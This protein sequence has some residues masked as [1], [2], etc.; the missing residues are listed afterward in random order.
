MASQ[1]TIKQGDTLSGIARANNTTVGNIQTSNPNITDVNKIQAGSI[2]NIPSTSNISTSNYPIN[3]VI[4]ASDIQ[5]QKSVAIPTPINDTNASTNLGITNSIQ[6]SQ[7]I[8]DIKNSNTN[9]TQPVATPDKKT[10]SDKILSLIGMSGTKE[11]FTSDLQTEQDITGKTQELNKLNNDIALT[12]QSYDNQI[13]ELRKNDVGAVGGG[14]SAS[15]ND[16]TRKKN[17]DLANLAIRKSVALN[18]LNTANSIIDRKVSAKFEPIDNQIKSYEQL[19]TLLQN[20][21][22][23]KEKLQAQSNLETQKTNRDNV[24]SAL[25]DVYAN[26]AIN[27]AP[28]T[29]YNN[30]DKI[31][32]D[33]SNNKID[34][35]TAINLINKSAGKYT[36]KNKTSLGAGF[37]GNLSSSAQAVV[38][39]PNLINNFT[40][41][42]KGQII[43]E[44]SQA[45]YDISSLGSKP[46]SD[47]A[48]K[49]INQSNT[50]LSS[51]NDL[52]TIVSNNQDKIGPITGLS[53]LNPY[54]E[55]RKIQADIDRVKQQVGKSLEGGVLRKEDEVKYKK[56]LATITDT[57]D[58]ALYKI[59]ELIKNIDKSINDY[60]NLQ[61]GS[62]R[63]SNVTD[64][65]Q[66]KDNSTKNDNKT[67]VNTPNI[68]ELRTKYGY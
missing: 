38:D 27:K 61:L 63:S 19:Y 1:Y 68:S 2:L 35:I 37:N 60:K 34:A 9:N 47:T 52:R 57:P 14:L 6:S 56:I 29:I 50:A 7:A 41:T 5:N 54:S 4:S 18:D 40:P 43:T 46:L 10:V 13:K 16:L 30:I 3:T 15:I 12:T 42:V 31:S 33:F 65:L 53:A 32:T 39:N 67:V 48:I 21:L 55:A 51:L 8:N 28:E 17:E 64:S 44:L 59:D 49:E 66:K 22:T 20:D 26:L 36:A 25:K 45:G 24:F 11:Q 58:T 23:E 62:G